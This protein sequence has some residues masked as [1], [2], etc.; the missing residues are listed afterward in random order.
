MTKTHGHLP[1]KPLPWAE[2]TASTLCQLSLRSPAGTW[3]RRRKESISE[4]HQ[5]AQTSL[6]LAPPKDTIWK[7]L[8]QGK[9]EILSSSETHTLLTTS[10]ETVSVVYKKKRKKGS[11]L[12]KVPPIERDWKGESPSLHILFPGGGIIRELKKTQK[13]KVLL[14]SRNEAREKR[15]WKGGCLN[16]IKEWLLYTGKKKPVRTDL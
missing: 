15:T 11:S 12:L 5:G 10:N 7:S 2:H 4:A 14:C 13:E 9:V 3:W 6:S 16:L 8:A 1:P